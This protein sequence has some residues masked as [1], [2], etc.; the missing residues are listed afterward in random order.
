MGIKLPDILE[1]EFGREVLINKLN[2][3][4]WVYISGSFIARFFLQKLPTLSIKPLL[5]QPVK[6]NKIANHLITRSVFSLFNIMPFTLLIPFFI[7]TIIP[8]YSATASVCWLTAVVSLIMSNHLLSIYLKWKFNEGKTISYIIIGVIAL[9]FAANYIDHLNISEKLSYAIGIIPSNPQWVVLFIATPLLLYILNLKYITNNLYLSVS[10]ETNNNVR[11][12]AYSFLKSFG[13]MGSMLALEAKL[14]FRN[15]RSRT[16]LILSFVFILYGLMIYKDEKSEL[17]LLFIGGF[18]S[19]SLFMMNYGQFIPAWHSNYF[20]LFMAQNISVKK[21]LYSAYI[22]M[23]VVTSISFII[24]TAYALLDPKYVLFNLCIVLYN[25]GVNLP[26]ILLAGCKSRKRLDL[27]S[28]G[29]GFNKGISG[30]Q[31]LVAIPLMVFPILF[32]LFFD[33]FFSTE[34]AFI[35]LGLM[36]IPGILFHSKLLDMI[37]KAYL[38]EK[39]KILSAYKNS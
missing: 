31:Y 15:K 6:R 32:L 33:L 9:V 23:V 22:L 3:A 38:S 19:T 37:S 10:K 36:G 27:D 30:F 16:A 14:I 28:S 18:M 8:E 1:K 7:K 13:D 39:Y 5:L 35:A 26:L 20:S 11:T 2:I 17:F 4:V 24:S 29:M 25:L 21:F 34:G 12:E